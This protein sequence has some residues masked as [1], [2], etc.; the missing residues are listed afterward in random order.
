MRPMTYPIEHSGNTSFAV[1]TSDGPAIYPSLNDAC[2]AIENDTIEIHEGDRDY[3]DGR[4]WH[5][6]NLDD[7]TESE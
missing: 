2:D 6:V 7:F 1:I 3:Y 4:D 5:P